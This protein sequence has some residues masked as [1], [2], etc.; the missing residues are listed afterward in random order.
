MA[1]KGDW[2]TLKDT[3]LA[4]YVNDS[5]P[6]R[7][8]EKLLQLQQ[9]TLG[10]YLAYKAQLLRL[11]FEWEASLPE[12]ERAPNFLQKER[13]LAGLSLLL[14]DKVR[15]KFPENFE[16]ARQWAKLKDCKLQFQANLARREHQP[17]INEQPHCHHH[18]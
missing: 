16:E 17:I 4:K 3:F 10:L 11:W 15:G 6:E 1:R 13:F 7:L 2:N 18:Q 8:W 12:G 9:N 14:Q 5:S